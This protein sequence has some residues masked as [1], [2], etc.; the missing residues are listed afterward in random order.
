[1]TDKKN[2]NHQRKQT[3]DNQMN[4]QILHDKRN[5]TNY[6]LFLKNYMT[7]IPYS[8]SENDPNKDYL[9]YHQKIVSTYFVDNPH[10][11][12]LLLFQEPG[13]GKTLASI[14]IAEMMANKRKVIFLSKK[15]LQHNFKKDFKKYT[16]L[17]GSK[18]HPDDALRFRYNFISSNAGNMIE[19][20]GQINKT[21][22]EIQFEKT[23]EDVHSRVN[24][25]G[26]LL[27]IDE[28]HNF[29]NS[30]VSGSKNA[31]ALYQAIMNATDIKLVFL[32]ATPIVNDPF[33]LVPCFNMLHGTILLP[34]DYDRFYSSYVDNEKLGVKNKERF[35]NRIFGLLSYYGDWY[36]SGGIQKANETIKRKNFPDQ[37]PTIV[38]YVPMSSAQFAAYS[39][40]RDEETKWKGKKTITR[41]AMQKP[42]S[43]PG[44]TYRVMSRQISNYFIPEVAKAKKA[45]S[46]GYTKHIERLEEEHLIN[47]DVYSPKMKRI[48][49]N[50]NKNK[51]I[52]VVYSSFVSGEGLYI[53]AKILE[54]H[55]WKE[56]TLG[57]RGGGMRHVKATSRRG[58][59]D[60]KH[61]LMEN[62]NR[63][64][65]NNGKSEINYNT[66][67]KNITNPKKYI[68]YTGQESAEDRARL[69]SIFSNKRN[70]DGD[71][72]NLMLLSGAGAEGLDLRN[73]RHI[74][75]ME[76]YWNYG[77][78]KQIIARAV[79][80][81]SHVDFDDL[82]Q[83]TVQPY[84]Y[85]SDYPESF[86]REHATHNMST[87]KGDSSGQSQENSSS[88][89]FPEKK[90]S[91]SVKKLSKRETEKTTDVH[92]YTSSIKK[93][94]I[95]NRF[96]AA[97]LEA[98]IDCSIHI[99]KSPDDVKKKINCVMCTPTDSQL[100]HPSYDIDLKIKNPCIRP[101]KQ[102]ISVEEIYYNGKSYYY[103]KSENGVYS[104]FVY[105][106]DIDAYV[107]I[108]RSHYMYDTLINKLT[109]Y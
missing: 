54:A 53:F 45:E 84:I 109:E 39:H 96:Y 11:R 66:P 1:M 49:N 102:T 89:T 75:I 13:T 64:I 94:I 12:G 48:M 47:L 31:M 20:V 61:A 21:K 99:Q 58:G 79:R 105:K 90:T 107:E 44:S 26:I 40:A 8:N 60:T 36:S 103:K 52:G 19:Q 32:T 69:A 51:G 86:V 25:E 100:F 34:T 56:Y 70:R 24:L 22:E 95:N 87:K 78:I 82:S 14:A 85:L 27:I 43:D 63:V 71:V 17:S 91:R 108:D 98:S 37:L 46:R 93:N 29:F 81:L 28:A 55:G 72:I 65:Y 59:D 42:K 68:F 104:L 6:P 92:L 106:P 15:S 41:S 80:Y 2:R 101:T 23:L 5:S 38:E 74:H 62:N 33:E 30:I 76:P 35:K 3:S 50:I 88:L 7:K 57:P 18:E 4:K 83:R 9:Q 73:V 10:V 16:Q 97:M 67:E 77:R